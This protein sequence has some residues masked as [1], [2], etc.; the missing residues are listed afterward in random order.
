MKLFTTILSF[1]ISLVSYAQVNIVPMPAEV[2]MGSGT[3]TLNKNTALLLEGSGLEKSA[4][5]LNEYLKN[6]LVLH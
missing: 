3:F 1:A 4:V 5:V 6:N 2:K